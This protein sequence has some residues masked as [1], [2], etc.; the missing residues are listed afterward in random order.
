[1]R[2]ANHAFLRRKTSDALARLATGPSATKSMSPQDDKHDGALLIKIR[3][4]KY[5][6]RR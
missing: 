1:M 5:E 6:T 4:M 3:K 2:R